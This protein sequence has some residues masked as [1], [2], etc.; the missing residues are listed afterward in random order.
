MFAAVEG[1]PIAVELV[2]AQP[3]PWSAP[4]RAATTPSANPSTSTP[5]VWTTATTSC[6]IG[7]ADGERFAAAPKL[8]VARLPTF[9]DTHGG[10]AGVRSA[11]RAD[12]DAPAL[13]AVE[14]ALVG[15]H[16]DL[17]EQRAVRRGAVRQGIVRQRH[18]ELDGQAGRRRRRCA[19]GRWRPTARPPR[20]PRSSRGTRAAP[21][22]TASCRPRGR[23]TAAHAVAGDEAVAL[24]LQVELQ[25]HGSTTMS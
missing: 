21:R 12:L 7:H 3:A 19:A 1:A 11:R 17:P 20:S 24:E 6:W 13:V 2:D 4:R 15:L 22:A 25:A 23:R 5:A 14:A 16:V 9:A 10:P 18:L 8:N